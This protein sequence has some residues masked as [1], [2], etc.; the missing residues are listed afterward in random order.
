MEASS[1]DPSRCVLTCPQAINSP[2]GVMAITKRSQSRPVG[3]INTARIKALIC[4]KS[5]LVAGRMIGT[6]GGL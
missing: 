3:L 4:G 5:D 1:R 6:N 2:W